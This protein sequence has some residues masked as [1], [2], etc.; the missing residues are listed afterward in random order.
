[1]PGLPDLPIDIDGD[2]HR[3]VNGDQKTDDLYQ[4]HQRNKALADL[5]QGYQRSAKPRG[6]LRYREE[7]A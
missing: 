4:T 2:V 5:D 3:Q 1:M 6:P 7:D